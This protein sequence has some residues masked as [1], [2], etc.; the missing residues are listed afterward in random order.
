MSR[1]LRITALGHPEA[2]PDLHVGQVVTCTE[3]QRLTSSG[4]VAHLADGLPSLVERCGDRWEP[5]VR[6]PQHRAS[7]HGPDGLDC[8]CPLGDEQYEPD[9]D[10][11]PWR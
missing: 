11:A 5:V 9:T 7:C 2:E 10:P 8:V 3:L 6:G 4:R 1:Q